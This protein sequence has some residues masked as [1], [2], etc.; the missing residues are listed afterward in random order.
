MAVIVVVLLSSSQ[1][2]LPSLMYLGLPVGRCDHGWGGATT[3]E[4]TRRQ[5]RRIGW[6]SLT[7]LACGFGAG[8][9]LHE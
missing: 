9:F 7:D 3:D 6:S 2:F 4:R 1:F 5:E 8:G